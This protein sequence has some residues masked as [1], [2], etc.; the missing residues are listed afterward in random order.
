[1][2]LNRHRPRIKTIL[3]QFFTNPNNLLL[4]QQR[5]LVRH[6]LGSPRP[7]RKT[8]FALNRITTTNQIEPITRYPMLLTELTHIHTLNIHRR[9]QPSNTHRDLTSHPQS[10]RYVPRHVSG[11]S[12]TNT[13]RS[14]RLHAKVSGVISPGCAS[15]LRRPGPRCRWRSSRVRFGLVMGPLPRQRHRRGGGRRSLEGLFGPTPVRL[16]R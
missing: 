7:L 10:V 4:N 15:C 11:M 1:M 12:C 6:P 8:R 3:N 2:P 14:E 9:N 13:T 5:R 16:P